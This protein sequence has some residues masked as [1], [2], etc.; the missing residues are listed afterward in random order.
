L[1]PKLIAAIAILLIAASNPAL[2][3]ELSVF[4]TAEIDELYNS[5][6]GTTS[7]NPK[8]DWITAE[9]LGGKVEASS[10]R[11]D[12]YLTYSTVFA[13][14]AWYQSLDRFAR[15]H[16]LLINDTELLSDSTTLHISD[17][18]LRGNAASG[19]FFTD[20]TEPVS[21]QLLAALLYNYRT[22]TQ[23]NYFSAG[24]NYVNQNKFT[25]S[26]EVHQYLFSTSSSSNTQD[27]TTGLSFNQ[28]GSFAINRLVGERYSIGLGYQFDDFRFSDGVPTS[29]SHMP[30]LRFGWGGGTPF[31]LQVS[32]GPVI[33]SSS[34][35]VIGGT[36][37][38]ATTTVEPGFGV[39]A[40]YA[41]ERFS[42]QGSAGEG[43]GVSAGFG[44]QTNNITASA[45]V[46][47]KLTRRALLFANVGYLNFSGSSINGYSFSY[48]VGASYRL[49][50]HISLTGEYYGYRTLGNGAAA[51]GLAGTPG[52][53]AVT[54]V[55]MFGVVFQL[56]PWRWELD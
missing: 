36:R 40:A 6:V 55:F 21:P 14:N 45:L 10:R 50:R 3:M 19:Q 35:G 43:S 15:D 28:G 53:T 47:Y 16:N 33:V 25:W 56:A 48:A 2:A 38:A 7:N 32:A 9:L 13:E 20:S 37:V 4:P 31:S 30:M 17:S 8:G 29:D 18:F 41:G 39:V 46:Q 22:T 26:S 12:F 44:G 23:S 1:K 34:A 27:A 5:N 54:N 11:R 42:L 52:Q 51:V 49:T 24:L